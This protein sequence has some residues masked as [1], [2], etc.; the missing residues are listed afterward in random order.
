MKP[1]LAHLNFRPI[2]PR[3]SSN[4]RASKR[5]PT[6]QRAFIVNGSDRLSVC[7]LVDMSA[8][9]AQVRVSASHDV[10]EA[11]DLL[12]AG[13]TYLKTIPV[14]VKWRGGDRLGVQ[15]LSEGVYA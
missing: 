13:D 3:A 10:P 12:I 7:E 9:G 8:G 6:S 11:F 5:F 2:P 14:E 1:Q 15:Y 4:R